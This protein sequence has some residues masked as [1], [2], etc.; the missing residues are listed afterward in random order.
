MENNSPFY[1]FKWPTPDTFEI[2]MVLG[3]VFTALIIFLI[4]KYFESKDQK[5]IHN[6]QHFLFMAK[7][8]GLN[9]FQFKILKNMA[10]Y[11]R[12]AH[13]N[14]LV[15]SSAL[16]ESTLTDFI[17]YLKKQT[18]DEENLRSIF[19]DLTI[20]YERLYISGTQRKPLE[21]MNDIEEGE[22][23]YLTTESGGVYLGKTAGRGSNFLA[24][25]IFTPAK[26]FRNIEN[27]VPVSLHILRINDAE[28]LIRTNTIGTDLDNLKVKMSDDFSREREFRHPYI[29]VVIPAVVTV[30]S[31]NGTTEPELIEGTI[32]KL[33]EFECVL[34][35]PSPL[36][37]NRE[38]PV[39]FELSKYKFNVNSR[40]VS[41]KTVETENVYY[42]TFKFLD[43]SEPGKVILTRYVAE[44]L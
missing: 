16:F 30:V 10:S 40:I 34:R 28:Y 15:K 22:I 1:P 26:N 18:E 8:K 23:L 29:N 2:A 24:L 43:M 5:R 41:S 6:Y 42:L 37:Y 39:N 33:N 14:E 38:Y 25:K 31:L 19:R 36:E 3:L 9:N 7:Q 27:E 35:I 21:S 32:L 11:L 13:P 4:Y 20:I 44:S 12:L 17:E